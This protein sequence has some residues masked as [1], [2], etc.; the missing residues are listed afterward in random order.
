MVVNHQALVPETRDTERTWK[1]ICVRVT[2]ILRN[3]DTITPSRISQLMGDIH[4]VFVVHDFVE[5]NREEKELI[6]KMRLLLKLVNPIHDR[7]CN[8]KEPTELQWNKLELFISKNS[9]L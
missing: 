8:S 9:F 3:K 1:N 5:P 6:K 7:I 2:D 4:K